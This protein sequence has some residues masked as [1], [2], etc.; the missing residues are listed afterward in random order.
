MPSAPG[1]SGKTLVQKLGVKPGMRVRVVGLDG[2]WQ[3][4]VGADDV[5]HETTEVALHHLFVTR[6]DALRAGLTEAMVNMARGGMIWVSWPKKAS[7][8]PTEVTE[9]TI[10]AVAL[11]MGLVDIKV[12]AVTDV[13]SGLKL[14]R[15]RA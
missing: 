4:I 14:T 6:V 11:P 8:V 13:W 10:R 15:R 2:D 7:G 1:Y 5:V 9:D 3:Q 12:C